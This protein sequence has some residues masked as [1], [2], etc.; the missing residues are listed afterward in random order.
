MHSLLSFP[1]RWELKLPH[2][3]VSGIVEIFGRSQPRLTKPA[4]NGDRYVNQRF[5]VDLA[6]LADYSSGRKMQFLEARNPK[7]K[8]KIQKMKLVLF[9]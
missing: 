8:I 5:T 7:S 3:L 9:T 6:E 4:A 1:W 2:N